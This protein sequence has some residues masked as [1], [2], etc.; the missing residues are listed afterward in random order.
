MPDQ[1]QFL[2]LYLANESCLRSFVR[3]IVRDRNEFDDVFQAVVLVLWKNFATYDATR[4]FGPW[5]R[6]VAAREILR[7]RRKSGRCP[8]PFSPEVIE[9]ILDSY[10][11][12]S[13]LNSLPSERMDA[14]E[15]CINSLP[16]EMSELL[17]LRYRRS[18]SIREI[19]GS[20]GGTVASVQKSLS[21]LR[22]KLAECV[23]RRLATPVE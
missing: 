22:F 18:M 5:S 10:E 3:T 12:S 6:S 17:S 9:A 16:E 1:D 23:E 7:V 4:P 19:S 8:T 11:H 14:L 15:Q 2:E 21:R 20:C 13:A